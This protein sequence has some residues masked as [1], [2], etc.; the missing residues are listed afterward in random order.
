[1]GLQG[2]C[3]SP[4][5]CHEPVPDTVSKSIANPAAG[6]CA[7]DLRSGET[8]AGFGTSCPLAGSQARR[9][10]PDA[11]AAAELARLAENHAA[12][13]GGHDDG[14]LVRQPLIRSQFDDRLKI[15]NP[16]GGISRPQA[17]VENPVA[18]RRMRAVFPIGPIEIEQAPGRQ[19]SGC[20]G[21]EPFGGAPWRDMNHI[22]AQNRIGPV[23]LPFGRCGIQQN[24]GAKIGGFRAVTMCGDAGQRSCVAIAGLPGEMRERSREINRMFARSRRQFQHQPDRGQGARQNLTYGFTVTRGGGRVELHN[25]G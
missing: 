6:E 12:V 22:D 17:F 3:A 11:G 21:H 4:Y 18:V 15:A 13:I 8:G 7:G 23:Y 9:A 5:R 10:A 2:S 24:G 25:G 16:P 14:F 19:N 20:A 1:M